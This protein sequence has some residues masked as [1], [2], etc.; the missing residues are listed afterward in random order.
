MYRNSGAR[1]RVLRRLLERGPSTVEE[2]ATD[3]GVVPVTM[4]SHLIAL[5]KQG[6]VASEDERGHVG[7]P[8]RRFSLT[9]QAEE[10]L[11]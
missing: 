9:R 6:L 8:R 2:L 5:H 11:P 4:R 7:R 1:E 3:L 10:L